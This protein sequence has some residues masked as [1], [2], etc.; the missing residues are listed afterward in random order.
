M[1]LSEIRSVMEA[2]TAAANARQPGAG[3]VQAQF[4]ERAGTHDKNA[5]WVVVGGAAQS[6]Q[7]TVWDSAEAE[8]EV[9]SNVTSA[10]IVLRTTSAA[11]H[12]E[13]TALLDELWRQCA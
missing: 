8:I 12:Q 4:F 11:N 3:G 13:L 7:L 10:P 2:W 1:N 5:V 9:Y 6:G